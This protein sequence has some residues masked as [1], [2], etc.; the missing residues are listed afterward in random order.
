M[1]FDLR[2][3]QACDCFDRFCGQ[4]PPPTSIEFP[5]TLAVIS[6]G[7]LR[8][9]VRLQPLGK[10]RTDGIQRLCGRF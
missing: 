4:A 2:L 6:I 5:A 8:A 9:H 10:E 1:W 7:S 3:S